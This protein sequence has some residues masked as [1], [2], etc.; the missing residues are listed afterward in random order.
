MPIQRGPPL[1][2]AHVH[3]ESNSSTSIWLWWKKPDFTTVKI[4]N[5]TVRFS[6]W[7]LRNTSLV[8][9]YTSSSGEDILIGGLKPFT[10]Y[11]FAVQS[12]GVDMDGPFGSVV[13]LSTLPDREWLPA[14]GRQLIFYPTPSCPRGKKHP[15][16]P[17]VW[18]EL[19]QKSF[20]EGRNVK[21]HHPPHC[22]LEFPN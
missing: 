16:E 11:E 20:W 12:H 18:A 6:P 3:A 22:L 15:S 19:G 5:Y 2:P 13:E 10:K 9:Y 21:S 7:G 17:Q 8:T 1:P 4:V 14:S